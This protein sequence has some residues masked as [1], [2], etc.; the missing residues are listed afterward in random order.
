MILKF[1]LK[2]SQFEIYFFW[3]V[4]IN[5]DGEIT[6]TKVVDLN[7]IYNFVVYDSKILFVIYDSN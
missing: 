5:L 2:F 7:V 1:Y 4:Q 3:M 6:K